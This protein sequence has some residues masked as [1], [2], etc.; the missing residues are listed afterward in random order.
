M[1]KIS[2]DFRLVGKT[3]SIMHLLKILARKGAI[4]AALNLTSL[5]GGQV[6]LVDVLE[7]SF[8]MCKSISFSV[9]RFINIEF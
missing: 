9:M 4:I 5:I 8:E 7:F 6:D 1:G 2:A 3:P